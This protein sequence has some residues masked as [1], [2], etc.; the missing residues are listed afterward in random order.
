[1]SRHL[2][3]YLALLAALACRER[4]A[5]RSGTGPPS[6]DAGLVGLT[7]ADLAAAATVDAAF[8]R[9]S[10]L[11]AR[12][13][14]EI[15]TAPLERLAERTRRLDPALDGAAAEATAAVGRIRDPGDRALAAPLLSAAER[16]PALL[17]QSRDE[18]LAGGPGP[19]TAGLAALGESVSRDLDAYRRSRGGWALTAPPEDE[20]AVAF[21]Q[22]RNQLERVENRIGASLP[23]G[24]GQPAPALDQPRLRG[25]I[26]VA[27]SRG[28]A[29]AAVVAHDRRPA[30]QR[31]VEAQARALEAL[32]ELAAAPPD[33]RQRL[34]RSLAY[35][36]A[37]AEALEALA[38]YARLVAARAGR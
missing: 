13:Q 24:P 37:K 9:L 31:W 32:L 20:T 34:A 4:P 10:A 22:A 5:P 16:W 7:L 26:E 6:A 21:T 38:E 29:A 8:S 33:P 35:Q 36:D 18:R 12:Y 2:A 25:E 15:A 23:S 3:L 27:V 11:A 17:R 14:A 28:R 1:M 19:A 30:A